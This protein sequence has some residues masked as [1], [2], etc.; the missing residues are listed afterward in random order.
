MN[1]VD[2]ESSRILIMILT[3]KDMNYFD[4]QERVFDIPKA[5]K[6]YSYIIEFMLYDR[7]KLAKLMDGYKDV[8]DLLET[9]YANTG[10][11][12]YPAD[13]EIYGN[14]LEKHFP[15]DYEFVPN[16]PVHH[17]GH[18]IPPSREE[19]IAH[20]EELNNLKNILLVVTILSY[21]GKEF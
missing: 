18:H 1:P 14:L 12:S 10:Q 21:N 7:K 9:C 13:Q 3:M 11:D 16:F 15:N 2:L 4:F 20:I 17:Q 5:N 6:G 8:D 19:L